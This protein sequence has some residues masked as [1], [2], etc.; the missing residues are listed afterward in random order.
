MEFCDFLTFNYLEFSLVHSNSNPKR[1]CTLIF[2][3]I[4]QGNEIW[5][6]THLRAY[7]AF[8]LAPQA[9]DGLTC[10]IFS[11]Y[12]KHK[13]DVHPIVQHSAREWDATRRTRCSR[14]P[15][16]FGCWELRLR[17]KELLAKL[18][19]FTK[20]QLFSLKMTT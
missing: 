8:V 7:F 12:F 6:V 3:P 19:K 2:S 11:T 1:L 9:S 16:V 14:C 17:K 10:V 5:Q 4:Q 18:S 15:L 13:K 20:W